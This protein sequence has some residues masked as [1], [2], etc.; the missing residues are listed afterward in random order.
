MYGFAFSAL[1]LFAGFTVTPYI[2]IYMQTN[3]GLRAEQILLIYLFGG[4]ATLVSSRW[5]GRMTDRFGKF[6]TFRLLAVAVVIPLVAITL[7]RPAPFWQVLVV[8]TLFLYV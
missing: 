8:T 4:A 3:A 7:L 6:K 1:T 5:V 2:T